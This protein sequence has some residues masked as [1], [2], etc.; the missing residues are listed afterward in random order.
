LAEFREA[1]ALFDKRGDGNIRV[2]DLGTVLRAMGQNP[3]EEDVR[4][5]QNE[6]DPDSAWCFAFLGVG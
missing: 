2:G 5:I 4:K 3:S 6:I 1:F